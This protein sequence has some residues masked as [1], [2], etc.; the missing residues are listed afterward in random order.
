M[1][2]SSKV[3]IL[4]PIRNSLSGSTFERASATVAAKVKDSFPFESLLSVPP[5]LGGHVALAATSA[6]LVSLRQQL[7]RSRQQLRHSRS[8]F[9][10][11]FGTPG[12]PQPTTSV[13]P[14]SHRPRRSQ[15]DPRQQPRRSRTTLASNLA[16]N[17]VGG[18]VSGRWLHYNGPLQKEHVANLSLSLARPTLNHQARKRG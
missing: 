12:Q 1:I 5:I 4:F 17:V 15:S 7:G 16:S 14:V 3:R 2:R 8:P 9:A 6:L 13:L 10:S 18:H 11:N